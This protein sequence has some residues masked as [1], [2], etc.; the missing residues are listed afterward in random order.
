MLHKSSGGQ[1]ATDYSGKREH[2][3]GEV[4]VA[5]GGVGAWGVFGT[6]T[7]RGDDDTGCSGLL[8]SMHF[9]QNQIPQR[10]SVSAACALILFKVSHDT[11]TLS[12]SVCR[13]S[14]NYSWG[15]GGSTHRYFS[16]N[17]HWW[18]AICSL[19]WHTHENNSSYPKE[20]TLITAFRVGALHSNWNLQTW[21]Y[22]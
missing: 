22:Y 17:S 10:V 1:V 16:T 19:K 6:V 5:V 13:I 12:L 3:W 7:K 9:S 4:G 2:G 21:Y 20:G 8:I 14:D 11:L 18:I 15:C